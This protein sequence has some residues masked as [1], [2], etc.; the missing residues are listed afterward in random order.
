MGKRW[1]AISILCSVITL[2]ALP[3]VLS[4]CCTHQV[5]EVYKLTDAERSV[6]P[7]QDGDVITFRNDA[8]EEFA[9]TVNRSELTKDFNFQPC[10]A[11]CCPVW[12]TLD[13]SLTE[14]S[15]STNA[16]I[17]PDLI[18]SP[19]ST[20]SKAGEI[21]FSDRD[22]SE[23]LNERDNLDEGSAIHFNDDLTLDCFEFC[24]ENTE[25]DG[26][27]FDEI[28]KVSI[29]YSVD[30]ATYLNLHYY[31]VADRGI[32]KIE[33]EVKQWKN[34]QEILLSTD[35]YFLVD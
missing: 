4:N 7:Y 35:E 18:L 22:Y 13:V 16:E 25:V 27:V 33:K 14:F 29:Y 23:V 12:R 10:A 21:I 3:F 6:L 5:K 34:N 11:E 8:N 30:T 19:Y 15:T 31:F 2:I 9:V 1:Q 20:A 17:F 28:N 24:V 26:E 32:I